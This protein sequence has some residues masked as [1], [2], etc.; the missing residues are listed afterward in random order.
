MPDPAIDIR[1]WLGAAA[2]APKQWSA[3]VHRAAAAQQRRSLREA[4]LDRWRKRVAGTTGIN[5][6]GAAAPPAAPP[7][8]YVCDECGA[9]F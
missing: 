2:V 4:T 6:N 5:L 7:A 9:A 3:L 8:E 1:S